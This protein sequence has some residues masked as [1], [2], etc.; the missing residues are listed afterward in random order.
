MGLTGHTREVRA[1]MKGNQKGVI[2]TAK[3]G[4]PKSS[5]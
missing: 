2:N 4:K 5:T 3:Q 1:E